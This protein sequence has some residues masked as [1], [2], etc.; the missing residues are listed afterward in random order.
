MTAMTWEA[1]TLPCLRCGR[2]SGRRSALRLCPSCWKYHRR[3]GTL[4]VAD[5]A[6]VSTHLRRVTE[7][8]CWEWLGGL[9]L[10]GYGHFQRQY[11]HRLSYETTR[12]LIPDGLHIDHLC[13]NRRCFNP[14]HLEAVPQG[15][16]TARGQCPTAITVRTNRC[17]RGHEFTPENTYIV[18]SSG[19]RRC[20]ECVRIQQANARRAA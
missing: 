12:G 8:G 19:K 16:N 17:Q 2:V 3:H 9:K 13:R 20:R 1:R 4:P 5:W 7:A 11:T 15:V 10:E 18:P 14:D 6:Y